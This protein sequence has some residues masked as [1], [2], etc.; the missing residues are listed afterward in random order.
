MKNFIYLSIISTLFI[1]C[2][3]GGGGES[4]P[5]NI[6]PTVPE[7]TIPA[8][9]KL[10]VNN[11]IGFQWNKSKDSDNSEIT[12]EIQIAKDNQFSDIVEIIETTLNLEEIELEKNTAYYWRIK[13]K[14]SEGLSSEYSSPFKFYTA[15]DAVINH[16]PFAPELVEPILN[17]TLN[18]TTATLKWDASDVD[19]SDE[20][21]YDIYL[22]TVN[23]P[24]EKIGENKSEKTFDVTLESSKQYYWKVIVKDNN[25]G[26]TVGQVWQFKTN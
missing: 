8:N 15:G 16:L 23:P 3:G 2:G 7:L 6:A 14:D 10:C 21:T 19:T 22:G 18:S 9:N 17:V 26:E 13:A 20:L 1:A 11:F 5:Q 12:Y 25:G 24:T 4:E